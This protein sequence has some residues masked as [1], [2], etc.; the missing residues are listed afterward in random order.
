M[1]FNSL[2]KKYSIREVFLKPLLHLFFPYRCHAC[3]IELFSEESILC[4]FCE[5]G[6][7]HTFNQAELPQYLVSESITLHSL[8]YY[9]KGHAAQPLLHA[10][11]YK[12]E[13]DACFDWGVILAKN[14]KAHAIEM[15][16]YLMPVPLHPQK[17]YLRGYNQS[18]YLARG[19]QA[20][21][22]SAQ[23]RLDL[24]KRV[25]NSNSQ[26]RKNRHKRLHDVRNVFE[27]NAHT[28]GTV[29]HIGLVDDVITTGATLKGIIELIKSKY[30]DI[31]ITIFVLAVTK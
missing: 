30:P 7:E 12:H 17:D 25:K 31:R 14:L 3:G 9:S 27:L 10:L 5:T 15:P 11:K 18:E 26:T 4:V 20:V 16:E 23:L 1:V 13:R 8:C 29:S 6:L 22:P 24:I 19:I 28:W 21:Y 2:I